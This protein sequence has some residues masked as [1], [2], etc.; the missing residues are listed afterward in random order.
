MLTKI[1]DFVKGRINDIILFIIVFLLVLLAFA[2]GYLSAKY[3]NKE[4]IKIENGTTYSTT[5]SFIS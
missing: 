4:P 2:A 1:Q 3:E 5:H